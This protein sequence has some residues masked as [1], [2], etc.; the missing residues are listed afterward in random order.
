[1]PARGKRRPKT[2]PKV[3]T[4][5]PAAGDPAPVVAYRYGAT[6]VVRIPGPEPAVLTPAECRTLAAV[7]LLQSDLADRTPVVAGGTRH[8]PGE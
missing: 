4:E 6:V 7:L 8:L 3:V 2:P 5:R 1:M